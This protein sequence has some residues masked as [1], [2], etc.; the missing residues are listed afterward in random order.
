[1]LFVLILGWAILYAD[2]TC[3][4]PL[5]SVIGEDLALTSA[6]TGALTSAYFLFYVLMQIPTG[7][8]GDRVGLKKVLMVMFFIAACGM[9]GLGLCGKTY[10]LL[11]LF[12][13]LHGFGAGGFY[14]PAFGTVLQVV[15][16]ARR[17]IS[18]ALM[19]VGMACGLLAGMAISGPVYEYMNDFRAPF[20][21][22][23]IPTFLVI[24]LYY[25]K[26]PNIRGAGQPSLQEYK[27]ILKDKDL[28]RI[29][30][31][32]FTALYGFWVAM[33][34]GPTFLAVEKGFSLLQSGFYTGL[35][36]ISAI[37]AG[38]FWGKMSDKWGRK[39]L[40]LLILPCS[41]LSLFMLTQVMS[42]A[43]VIIVFL[44][45]GMTANSALCPVIVSWLADLLN[46]RY[47]GYMGVVTGVHNSSI[48]ISA[49][50][51]PVVS[52]FLRDSLGSLAP[53]IF[54]GCLLMLMG[55]LVT[56]A[57]PESRALESRSSGSMAS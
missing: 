10:F 36:A 34:W 48:M 55:T 27:K 29:N 26:M 25:L 22:M 41:A 38:I 11:L 13:S 52:G 57:V 5:L 51:A 23:S 45:Y 1:M 17:G 33:T 50:V 15:E 30:F 6:Q 4:Y 32:M 20:I 9:L 40:A 43:G 54:F 14:P 31:V 16:P 8:V 12:V 37:P 56:L 49:I 47:P 3:L 7:F 39:R 18:T 21:L 28:W 2:R 53:A 24:G 35:V 46:D 44:V 42:P 19:G